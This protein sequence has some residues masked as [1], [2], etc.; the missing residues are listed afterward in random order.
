MVDDLV[1]EHMVGLLVFDFEAEV[2]FWL[3]DHFGLVLSN[4][5]G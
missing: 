3:V 4:S 2:S 5:L 1:F